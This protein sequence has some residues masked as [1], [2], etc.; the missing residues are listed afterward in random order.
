MIQPRTLSLRGRRTGLESCS[1]VP[2]F[3][4]D[5]AH[6]EAG[7]RRCAGL[8][9]SGDFGICRRTGR[10]PEIKSLLSFIVMK[11]FRLFTPPTPTAAIGKPTIMDMLPVPLLQHR[12]KPKWSP[13]ETRIV[14]HVWEYFSNDA[15][16]YVKNVDGG[17]FT[18]LTSTNG[19]NFHPS[20]QPL[21]SSFGTLN[22]T[23][24]T[25]G[26]VITDLSNSDHPQEM[27]IQPDG[28]IVVQG[29]LNNGYSN[30]NPF[31]ARYNPNGT[32]DVSFG[33]NG[34]V[35]ARPFEQFAKRISDF[36][37]RENPR[38]RQC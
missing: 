25:G 12:N 30:S 35:M 14:F 5:H 34:I 17:G 9:K 6:D 20:W 15:E 2:A 11:P 10:R 18:K 32:L 4:F 28:K 21:V 16:T 27:A 22:P 19:S 38:Q 29:H 36:A 37:R 24:G 13:D 31:L 7:R 3:L 26:K 8:P 33:T 23:F 1:L